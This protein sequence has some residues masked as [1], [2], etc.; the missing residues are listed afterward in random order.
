MKKAYI[1]P[2]TEIVCLNSIKGILGD[3]GMYDPQGSTQQVGT[4][5]DGNS[6][7]FDGGGV[8]DTPSQPSLW[9]D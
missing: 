3:P 8:W 1:Q 5:M 4:D 6:G 2:N 9:D 7:I